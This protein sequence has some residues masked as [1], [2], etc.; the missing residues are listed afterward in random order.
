MLARGFDG[1]FPAGAPLV[2][3]RADVLFVALVA[4]LLVP[5]RVVAG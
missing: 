1:S 3:R 2:L 4:L 5:A